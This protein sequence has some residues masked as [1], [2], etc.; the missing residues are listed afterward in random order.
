MALNY[1]D[2]E[3]GENVPVQSRV[4]EDDEHVPAHDVATL[5]GTVEADIA[6]IRALLGPA[7]PKMDQVGSIG[8]SADVQFTSQVLVKGMAIK[9]ISATQT[10]YVKHV[11]TPTSTNSMVLLP[12]EWSNDIEC[13]N[14][15]QVYMRASAA[16]GAACYSGR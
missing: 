16:G 3:L 11:A 6:A 13:T 14:A 5:P 1:P 8:T 4:N 15:D 10:L 12:G 2:P 9:N 7:T